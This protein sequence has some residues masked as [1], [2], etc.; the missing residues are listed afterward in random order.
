VLAFAG[1][2][3]NAQWLSG[4]QAHE[5]RNEMVEELNLS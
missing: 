3:Q 2:P 4:P 5:L 1:S